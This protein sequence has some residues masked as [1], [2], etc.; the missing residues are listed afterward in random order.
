MSNELIKIM[1]VILISAVLITT[2][3]SKLSEYSFLLLVAVICM[4]LIIS[5]DNVFGAFSALRTLFA[6]DGN[7]SKTYF[8][9]ALKALGISYITNFSADLCRDYGLGALA[10]SAEMVGKITIFVLSIP[11]MESVLNATLNFAGI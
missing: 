9:V 6:K 7:N 3:K 5:F 8:G 11:L 2:I 10:Q 1:A 4:V